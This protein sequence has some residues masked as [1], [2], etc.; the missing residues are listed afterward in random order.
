MWANISVLIQIRMWANNSE[1]ITFLTRGY[2]LTS[3]VN[4]FYP[5]FLSGFYQ[6]LPC[7]NIMMMIYFL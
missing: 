3:A 2:L 7:V 5:V 1:K 4:W 6:A